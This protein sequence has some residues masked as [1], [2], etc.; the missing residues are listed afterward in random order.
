MEVV[1]VDVYGHMSMGDIAGSYD[2][3]IFKEFSS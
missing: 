2:K 1:C 3:E